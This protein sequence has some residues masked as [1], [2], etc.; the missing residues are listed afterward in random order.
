MKLSI[1][2]DTNQVQVTFVLGQMRTKELI[3]LNVTYN[4]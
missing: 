3:I 2:A 4:V 1:Y